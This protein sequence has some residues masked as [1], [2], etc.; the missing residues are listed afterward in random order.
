M[1][2]PLSE[3]KDRKGSDTAVFI[4]ASEEIN[5]V[6]KEQWEHIKPFDTWALNNWHYHPFVP[7]FY[8]LEMKQKRGWDK[9]WIKRRQQRIY[10]YKGTS[11]IVPDKRQY[12]LDAIGKHKWIYWYKVKNVDLDRAVHEDPGYEFEADM[13]TIHKLGMA[14]VTSVFEILCR[15]EYKRIFLLGFDFSSARYFWT[16]RPEY[17]EVHCHHNKDFEGRKETD[18]PATEHMIPFIIGFNR[19]YLEPKGIELKIARKGSRLY[20][21]IDYLPIEEW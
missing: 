20:P 5:E 1:L 12:I 15:L 9:L 4:G 6:T 2:Y 19:N 21:D 16:D 8:H 11:F 14:S 10:E 3:I 17:G 7:R 18:P 13:N